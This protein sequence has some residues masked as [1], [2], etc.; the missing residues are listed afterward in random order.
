MDR[1]P[2]YGA[3]RNGVALGQGYTTRI[4]F[5]A[6]YLIPFACFVLGDGLTGALIY[7]AYGLVRGACLWVWV[8]GSALTK[9]STDAL[10]GDVLRLQPYVQMVAAVQLV[11]LGFA[12]AILVS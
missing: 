12:C 1:G 10:G 3:L 9:R 2:V 4:G 11:V 6:W 8:V 5:A 7:G